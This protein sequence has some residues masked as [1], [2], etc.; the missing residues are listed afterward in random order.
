M[1]V[2][3]PNTVKKPLRIKND[4]FSKD[5][6]LFNKEFSDASKVRFYRDFHTLLNSGLE[7]STSLNVI[8]ENEWKSEEIQAL[9]KVRTQIISGDPICDSM[10]INIALTEFEY[11]SIKIAEST[12]RIKEVMQQLADYFEFRIRNKRLVIQ[13][14]SYPILILF[15]AF[16][17]VIFMLLFVVP[18]FAEVFKRFG[19]DLPSLT[20]AI[21]SFSAFL[22]LYF[23]D[24]L[25]FNILLVLFL[26]NYFKSE[27]G[28]LVKN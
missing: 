13:I 18:M 22:K 20:I 3:L 21:I 15:T 7:L 6:K 23:W 4:W 16:G 10:K 26:L 28:K 12:G 24:L 14:L 5:F 25:L 27:K 8:L 1:K 9:T 2:N 19:S 17:A 11:F